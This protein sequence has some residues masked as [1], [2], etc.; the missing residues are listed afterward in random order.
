MTPQPSTPYPPRVI[1]AGLENGKL[2]A[3]QLT[4]VMFPG[5]GHL[6]LHPVAAR[7]WNMLAG[8]CHAATGASLSATGT[9]RT[10]QAQVN[11]FTTRMS[12][13][14]FNPAAHRVDSTGRPITRT[15][16]GSVYYLRK[17]YE[18][19]AAPPDPKVPGSGSNH[20]WGIAVDTAWFVPSAPGTVPIAGSPLKGITSHAA[21]WAWLVENAVSLGWGWEGAAPGT[22][23]YEP[24][25]L[26]HL[27]GDDVSQRVKDCEAWFAAAGHPVG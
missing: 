7:A 18:P 5:I 23:G 22:A 20:G 6:S 11:A 27:H 26:R 13:G 25:H 1:P 8:L 4:A 14:P 9:Y 17:G 24:W 15:W 21:G 16:M 10:Y 12:L 3:C 19:V 2:T